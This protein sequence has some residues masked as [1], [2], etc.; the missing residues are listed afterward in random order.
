ME[1]LKGRGIELD[2]HLDRVYDSLNSHERR[3][4]VMRFS[5]FLRTLLDR[6]ILHRDLKACNLFVVNGHDLLLL[7]VEDITFAVPDP[8]FVARMLVQLT[9][10]VPA[11]IRMRDRM[12]F[13]AN[14]TRNLTTDRKQ[15]LREVKEESLRR[16]IVYEGVSGLKKESWPGHH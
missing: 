12:R 7:D 6:G 10:T 4:M 9:T 11:R 15:L 8:N 3:E 1:D 2:R 16:E 5:F 13:F 14:A